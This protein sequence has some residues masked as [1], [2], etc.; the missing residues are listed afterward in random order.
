MKHWLHILIVAWSVAACDMMRPPQELDKGKLLARVKEKQLYFSDISPM[1]SSATDSIDSLLVL[2]NLVNSWVE[3]QVMLERA[4][5]NLTEE[6]L[7]F[8]R[9]I[10]DYRKSL[11][12]FKYEQE[13]LRQ[14]MDTIVSDAEIEKYYEENK[15]NFELRDYV[16]NVTFVKVV[17]D[18]PKVG[19]VK[20]WL[21]S[22]DI[23]DKN[24]FEDY[25]IQY[26]S[27]YILEKQW[28]Y[29]D[30]ITEFIPIETINVEHFLKTT[31]RVISEDDKY[32][33]L[34]RI[35]DYKLKNSISPLALEEERIRSIILNKR[36]LSFLSSFR[37]GL[38]QDALSKNE[39]EVL[40]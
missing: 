19:K 36:K 28:M 25:C 20:E 14:K 1:L 27:S 37:K 5:L 4:R 33:Y 30:D 38:L 23:K 16:V 9:Q 39:A 8:E 12:L 31:R 21:F 6:Q 2:R 40:P 34:M 18:A 3:E 26:A 13:I 17:R 35:F 11:I 7:N 24:R 29:F 32:I 22:D 10:E 15:Q